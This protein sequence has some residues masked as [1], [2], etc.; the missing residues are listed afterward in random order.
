MSRVEAEVGSLNWS[1][2]VGESPQMRRVSCAG[3]DS[4][5]AAHPEERDI[6]LLLW[7]LANAFTTSKVLQHQ[8]VKERK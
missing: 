4:D 2:G 5:K 7:H 8:P 6:F 3:L 1:S